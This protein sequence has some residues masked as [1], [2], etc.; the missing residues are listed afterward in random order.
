[1][2][3]EIQPPTFEAAYAETVRVYDD[4]GIDAADLTYLTKELFEE[5]LTATEG[6]AGEE[7]LPVAAEAIT[8]F[9]GETESGELVHNAIFLGGDRVLGYLAGAAGICSSLVPVDTY[10]QPKFVR[11]CASGGGTIWKIMPV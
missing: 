1:M 3:R 8:S 4:A 7:S 11:R 10:G 2:K 5:L 6:S 9:P